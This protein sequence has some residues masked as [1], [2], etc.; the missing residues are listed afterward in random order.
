MVKPTLCVVIL[1]RESEVEDERRAGALRVLIGL[2]RAKRFRVPAPD[3]GVACVAGGD[4]PRGAELVGVDVVEGRGARC[5]LADAVKIAGV[6]CGVGI[7]LQQEGAG[8]IGVAGVPVDAAHALCPATGRCLTLGIDQH[9]ATAGGGGDLDDVVGVVGNASI[10][11]VIASI[12]SCV[13]AVGVQVLPIETHAYFGGMAAPCTIGADIEAGIPTGATDGG[14][15]VVEEGRGA[16][17]GLA[18]L[19][20]APHVVLGGPG[21]QGTKRYTCRVGIGA[22]DS[23]L[24]L[25]QAQDAVS[26]S[27][28][29]AVGIGTGGGDRQGRHA[30]GGA[31]AA[32][33]KGHG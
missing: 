13:Q 32:V 5:G 18:V 29:D 6:V 14:A 30:V 3:E 17:L 21:I 25:N 24:P 10:Q 23:G 15:A 33:A 7:G 22:G 28:A 27:N 2:G 12:G 20:L 8:V 19:G 11:N 26:V 1:P 16:G 4:L 9:S 31:C